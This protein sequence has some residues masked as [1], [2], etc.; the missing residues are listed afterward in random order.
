M[1]PLPP[2][3]VVLLVSFLSIFRSFT[4]KEINNNISMRSKCVQGPCS[5]VCQM[6]ERHPLCAMPLLPC[7]PLSH[8][9]RSPVPV[10][11]PG[12][13]WG[14]FCLHHILGPSQHSVRSRSWIQPGWDMGTH[15][16]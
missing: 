8:V 2:F 14:L 6:G 7:A 12:V 1:F 3:F 5:A 15:M 16:S 10:S 9:S 13:F 4:E 11:H